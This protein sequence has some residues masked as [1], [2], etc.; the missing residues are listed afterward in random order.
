VIPVVGLA[1]KRTF[2]HFFVYK[3]RFLWYNEHVT[4]NMTK[5]EQQ[6]AD[7]KALIAS[8]AQRHMAERKYIAELEGKSEEVTSYEDAVREEYE[9]TQKASVFNPSCR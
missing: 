1:L 8:I 5:L 2:F 9:A 7:R 4:N 3:V 6:L